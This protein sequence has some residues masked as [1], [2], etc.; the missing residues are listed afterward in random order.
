MTKKKAKLKE[1]KELHMKR[2][3]AIIQKNKEESN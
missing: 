2:L 3:K 1:A